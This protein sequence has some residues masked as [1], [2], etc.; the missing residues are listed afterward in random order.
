M[1]IRLA[2]R[3]LRRHPG[4]AISAIATAALGI[5]ASTAMFS[6]AYGVSIRPLPYAEPGRLIRIYEANLAEGHLEHDVS[7][8]TF[9]EWRKGAQTLESAALF[10]KGGTRFLT[11]DDPRPVTMMSVSPAF[12]DVLG[13]R[14]IRGQGFRPER[15]Y[16]RYTAD[17][18]AVLSFAAWKRLFGGRPDVVGRTFEVSGV[19][20]NDTY[21]IVGVMPESFVF[22]QPVDMWQPTKIVEEP[23][24]RLLRMWR[25]DRV[26]ARLRPAATIDQV[27]AE[28]EAI[29]ARLATEFQASNRGWTATV[30]SLHDSIIGAFGRA[31]WLLLAAVAVVLFVTCLNV[32][33]LL[34]ARA[35]ARRRETAVRAALGATNAQLCRLLLAEG[36]LLAGAGAFFGVLFAWL[37]VSSLKAAAPPGIPRLDAIALDLPTLAVAGACT[38][39]AVGVFTFAPMVRRREIVDGLRTGSTA[40]SQGVD[41]QAARTVLTVAQCAGAATL[42][43]LA[44]MLTRSFIKL[45]SVDLGWDP[46]GVLSLSAQP[47]LRSNRPWYQYVE[48]SDRLTARFAGTPGIEDAAITSQVPLSPDIYPATLARGG[49]E[50]TGDSARWSGVRH[51]VSDGYFRLMG[52]RLVAGR[53]FGQGDRFSEEQ[54]IRRTPA[55]RG[56]VVVGEAAARALWPGRSA[57]GQ[58]LWF[59]DVNVRWREVVGV[60]EDIQF[61]A[62]GESPALHVFVPWTQFPTGRPRLLVKHAGAGGSIAQIVREVAGRVEPGTQIDRVVSLDALVSRATAQP[63]FT[64]RIVAAFG[65]LALLLAAVGIYG[66]LSYL[67]GARTREIGIRFALGASQYAVLSDVLSRGVIPPIAGGVIGLAMAVALARTFRALF[68]DLQ[69]IDAGS[70]AAGGALL[71][72]VAIAAA[73][74]PALRASHVDP[75]RALREDV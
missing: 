18:E 35:V 73:L 36:F 10:S 33:G 19:G 53:T 60:V 3:S 48:W 21:R 31:A 22:D 47:P 41:R 75:A 55:Q 13:V 68:F 4:F 39:I 5:G 69:P 11:G 14:P 32:G 24:G 70:F 16:T 49:D 72:I 25:Y 62:V 63:R 42:V 28:L 51:H 43:I 20:D 61:H 23:V 74:G 65:A 37:G 46:A 2:F 1:N 54:L 71:V 50:S 34:I 67:V 44:V 29:S 45:T 57:I 52:I 58:M 12:F 38:L 26:V 66:T 8:A 59:P 6:V 17:D 30:E 40:A 7:I 15:E 9:H 27:R 56:V 64:S